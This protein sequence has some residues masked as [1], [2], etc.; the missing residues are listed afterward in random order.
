MNAN[1]TKDA[2]SAGAVSDEEVQQL[3]DAMPDAATPSHPAGD[4]ALDEIRPASFWLRELREANN[5]LDELYEHEDAYSRGYHEA[6]WSDAG[7]RVLDAFEHLDRMDYIGQITVEALPEEDVGYLD[8]ILGPPEERARVD[9]VGSH[10]EALLSKGALGA[11][12][13]RTRVLAAGAE[14][15]RFRRACAR[16]GVQTEYVGPPGTGQ[17]MSFLPPADPGRPRRAGDPE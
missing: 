12:Y 13:V 1:E 4:L 6:A 17:W 5:I 10:V 11:T 2:S 9:A 8:E 14:L 15:P 7:N 3:L 16:L